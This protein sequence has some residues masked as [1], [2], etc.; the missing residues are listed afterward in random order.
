MIINKIIKNIKNCHRCEYMGEAENDY[1]CNLFRVIIPYKLEGNMRLP[2]CEAFE[3]EIIQMQEDN[4]TLSKNYAVLL[5]DF[6]NAII[7]K[8]DA[9]EERENIIIDLE[10]RIEELEE[11]LDAV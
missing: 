5:A 11:R 8:Y 1:F 9:I 3:E 6:E 2:I 4:K 10:E 7:E